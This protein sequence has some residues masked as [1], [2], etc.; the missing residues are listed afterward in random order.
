MIPPYISSDVKSD[1]ERKLFDSIKESEELEELTCLHSLGL[2]RHLWKRQGEIDFVLVGDG[3]IVCLEV[4]GGRIARKDGVWYFKD[5]FGQ[6]N[7]KTE[8]PFSQVSTAMFSLKSQLEAKLGTG[9]GYMFVYGV[10]FPDIEFSEKSP[11]WDNDIVY[12]IRDH[13][14]PFYSYFRRLR[15]YWIRKLSPDPS[16]VLLPKTEIVN[17]LR[18]NFE[19]ATRLWDEIGKTEEI[20]T[21]FTDEQY[22]ALDQMEGNRRTIFTGPAGCGKTLLALEKARR[23]YMDKKRVLFLCFNKLLGARLS[24]DILAIDP[25]KK[26]IHAGPIHKYFMQEI[27]TAG[28][29]GQF[30]KKSVGKS[31]Q[32]IYNEILPAVFVNAS[33]SVLKD[34]YDYLILDEGQDLLNEDYLLALDCVLKGGLKEGSWSVFLDPGGQAKLF[35][36]FSL[37]AY[38]YLKN[39]GAAEYK[40]LLNVR[41]TIPIAIQSSVISGIVGGKAKTEGPKVE[42]KMCS[43]LSEMALKVVKLLD[44]LINEESVPPSCI[45]VLSCKNVGSMSLFS[46]GIRVPNYI[47][48]ANEENILNPPKDK[49][50]YASAQSYKGLENNVVLYIDV[51]SLDGTFSESTNYVAMTRARDKLYVF[52]YKKLEAEYQEK[53]KSYT[54]VLR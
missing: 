5:R 40:M 23:L 52:M 11:E 43:S 54:A 1:A 3:L 13:G 28:M 25:L 37:E 53:L 44:S 10:V 36:R 18:G 47:I 30:Q 46:S 7:Q 12:D 51:D 15:D 26:H 4:K 19:L 45:T 50:L 35:N 39:L 31:S 17:Y 38:N 16:R 27:T 32:E 9:S 29:N 24:K 21:V 33:E 48:E 41:N 20:L 2:S 8:G 42:Y 34:K 6:E 49:V 14:K 22:G